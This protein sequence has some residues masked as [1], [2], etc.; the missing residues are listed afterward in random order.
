MKNLVIIRGIPGSGKS[1][2]A[3]GLIKAYQSDGCT[4]AHFEADMF[5]THEDGSYHWNPEQIGF[6]HQWCQNQV[7]ESLKN[8]DVVIVSNTSVKKKDVDIYVKIAQ[9]AGAKCDIYRMSGQF[10][11]IHAVPSEIVQKMLD[12]F[13]DYSGELYVN[14]EDKNS[15]LY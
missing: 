14:P 9:E 3:N 6:A 11:N 8:C 13:E 5:F 1:T 4:T 10:Q 15:A 7:R 12:S 2:Y